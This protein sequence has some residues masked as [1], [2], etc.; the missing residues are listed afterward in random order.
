MQPTRCTTEVPPL[1][2]LGDG[3]LAACH[4]AEEI[5]DGVLQPKSAEEVAAVMGVEVRPTGAESPETDA[6]VQGV[7]APIERR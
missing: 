4:W 1:R 2:K 6:F 7:D 3:H 5:R